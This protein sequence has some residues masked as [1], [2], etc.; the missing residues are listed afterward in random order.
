[1]PLSKSVPEDVLNGLQ[2]RVH[3]VDCH[4]EVWCGDEKTIR[5]LLGKKKKEKKKKKKKKSSK[6]QA[7]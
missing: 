4:E 2:D 7:F 6:R 5:D 1:M 3:V